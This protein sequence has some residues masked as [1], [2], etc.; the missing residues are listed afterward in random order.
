[1]LVSKVL[2]KTRVRIITIIELLVSEYSLN[3]IL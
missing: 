2:L 3:K 1:M